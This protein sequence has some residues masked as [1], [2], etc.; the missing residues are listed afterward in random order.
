MDRLTR[1]AVMLRCS[2]WNV[3]YVFV[4]L[5][6]LSLSLAGFFKGRSACYAFCLLDVSVRYRAMHRCVRSVDC[7]LGLFLWSTGG[8]DTGWRTAVHLVLV[9]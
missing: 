1:V 4:S 8:E 5:V 9:Q 3:L 2:K 7:G 6:G